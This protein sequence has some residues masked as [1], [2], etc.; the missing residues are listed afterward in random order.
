MLR[1]KSGVRLSPE[2]GYYMAPG[3]VS[4]SLTEK[5]P[6]LMVA[7]GYLIFVVAVLNVPEIYSLDLP[8][9]VMLTSMAGVSVVNTE[10]PG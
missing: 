6:L 2:A 7:C 3:P 9:S 1:E 8:V 5:L 4:I 10:K